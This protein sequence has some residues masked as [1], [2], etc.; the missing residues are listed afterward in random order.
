[1]R[2]QP[3]AFGRIPGRIDLLYLLAPQ[4]DELTLVSYKMSLG[5][6]PDSHAGCEI[7]GDTAEIELAAGKQCGEDNA[8]RAK[9]LA[10][11]NA[12]LH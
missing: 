7:M 8:L 6:A 9:L 4:H 11:L 12:A 1:M 10:R 3:K 5:E 2:K